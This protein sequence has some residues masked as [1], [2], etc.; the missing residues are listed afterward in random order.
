MAAQSILFADP[1][2][3]VPLDTAA[4]LAIAGYRLQPSVEA[5]RGLL[6]PISRLAQV[7]KILASPTAPNSVAFSP[8]GK[9]IVSA[10][11]NGMLIQWDVETGRQLRKLEGRHN[12]RAW[13]VTFS[14]DGAT[15]V[16]G[17]DSGAVMFWDAA[18]GKLLSGPEKHH[19]QWVNRIVFSP[20]GT[21]LVSAS[22]D[23]TSSSGIPR[24]RSRP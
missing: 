22:D 21:T 20:D 19:E 6:V 14:P 4:L 15:I 12:A 1:T 24:R 3:N 17:D 23:G 13:T 10:G 5:R 16:S 2:M 9:T 8:D 18:S 7:R 11:D